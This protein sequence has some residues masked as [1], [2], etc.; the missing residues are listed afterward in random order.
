MATSIEEQMQAAINASEDGG[1]GLKGQKRT[2][3]VQP[4][5]IKQRQEAVIQKVEEPIVQQVQV[6]EPTREVEVKQS[7]SFM[8]PA[9]TQVTTSVTEDSIGKIISLYVLFEKHDQSIKDFIKGFLNTGDNTSAVIYS[10]LNFKE[11]G[12]IALQTIIESKKMGSAER[13]FALVAT[14][15]AK[16]NDIR[17]ML[18]SLIE[19]N[20]GQI[21]DANKIDACKVIES[22]IS[23]ISNEQIAIIENIG[24]FLKLGLNS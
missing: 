16:L 13:A 22:A 12:I 21:T 20:V 9:S 24:N 14:T 7:P 1:A 6:T 2:Q 19:L 8:Q 4:A 15:N 3:K 10:A 11:S 17:E 18:E 23:N 5:Q